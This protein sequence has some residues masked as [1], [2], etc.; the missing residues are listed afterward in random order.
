[1]TRR[2]IDVFFLMGLAISLCAS[3]GRA[4]DGGP[5]SNFHEVIPGVY[6]GGRPDKAGLEYLQG[7]GVKTDLDLENIEDVVNE[8]VQDGTKLQID[9]VAEEMSPYT[10]P[11]DAQVARI[12][13]L[14]N[15][16][17]RR[18]IFVHCHYGE[19]RTGVMVGLFRV[20][21]ENWT[22]QNAYQEML[23]LG[24][25]TSLRALKNYFFAKTG[26]AK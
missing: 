25:H 21:S 8:E 14:L 11:D 10:T 4:E 13:A 3:T 23:D 1:L 12:Q 24:F 17:N 20:V 19:D 22:Q 26:S 5:I 2:S 18:P 6:R 7:L 15:D 9:V 16:T